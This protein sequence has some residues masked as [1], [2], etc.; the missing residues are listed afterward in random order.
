MSDRP[1]TQQRLAA[2]LADLVE[3]L[4][5]TNVFPFLQ[6]FWK[7]MAREWNGID[8][9]RFVLFS[10][11]SSLAS[12]TS[13]KRTNNPANHPKPPKRMNKFLLLVRLYLGASFEYL[14]RQSWEQSLVEQHSSLITSIPLNAS[15]IKIPNGIRYHVIDVY[16]DELDKVDTPRSTQLPLELLLE[17]L[18][19][20]A[21]KSPT[22][23]VR[24][25]ASEALADERLRN[26]EG[27]EGGQGEDGELEDVDEE[28]EWNGFD[29]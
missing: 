20:I 29:D 12:S 18:R 13:N 6:A 11:S 21:Q 14:S 4:P 26:W 15:D 19:N 25:R 2:D 24:V 1:Q 17:P 22:K 7:T 3:I 8:V 16:V 10:L 27:G 5:D 23:A 28:D 9:L